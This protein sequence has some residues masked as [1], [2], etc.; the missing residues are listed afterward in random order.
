[1]FNECEVRAAGIVFL[2]A[3]IAFMNGFLRTNKVD[4]IGIFV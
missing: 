3:F 1:M 2:F 4:G